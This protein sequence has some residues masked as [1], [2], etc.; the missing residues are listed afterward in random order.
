MMRRTGLS[1]FLVMLAA[2]ACRR[3]EEAARV[4]VVTTPG[5]AGIGVVQMLAERFSAE[6]KV[7][8]S[9]VV[10]EERF[11]PGLVRSAVAEVVITTSPALQ[12]ELE[13]AGAVRLSQTIAYNDYLLV[14]PKRDP[15]RAKSAKTAAEALRRIAR[16]D[17]AFCSPVDVP[18]LRHRE[19]LLWAASPAAPED[20]RRYRMCKGTALEVL[21]EASR[22]GAYTLTDRSTFESAGTRVDLVP[23]LQGTPMLHNDV[24]VLLIRGTRPHRNAEWFVQWVMSYRGR[25]AI[26]RYRYDGEHRLFLSEK[27]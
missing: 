12:R 27:R 5:L 25:D 9:I 16:R 13:R 3:G 8:A 20:D 7:P 11:V 19:A 10:T 18:H 6:S 26:D 15:A 21:R 17:R 23:L 2:I 4:T 24:A 22:L 1:A 14:G